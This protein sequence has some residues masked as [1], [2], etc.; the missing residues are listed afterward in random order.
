[1]DRAL[2]ERH[3][4]QAYRHVAEGERH[5]A[6]Q[7]AIVAE[8]ERNGHDAVEARRLLANFTASQQLHIEGR[9]RLERQLADDRP[10]GVTVRP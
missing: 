10:D 2:L 3:L 9:D 6:Q 1:M 8:L 5:L 4:Q 7:R